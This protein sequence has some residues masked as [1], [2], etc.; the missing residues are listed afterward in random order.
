MATLRETRFLTIDQVA[1]R[2]GVDR[3]HVYRLI[4]AGELTPI[5]VSMPGVRSRLRIAD[6]ELGRFI[7]R[8][9]VAS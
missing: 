6:D 3:R 8:R 5:D 4:R 1:E 7:S 2:L 9:T